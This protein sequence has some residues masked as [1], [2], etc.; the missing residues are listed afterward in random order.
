M[1]LLRRL[2]A[3]FMIGLRG[4]GIVGQQRAVPGLAEVTADSTNIILTPIERDLK[5]P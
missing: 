5:T 2:H 1:D 3:G 4:I